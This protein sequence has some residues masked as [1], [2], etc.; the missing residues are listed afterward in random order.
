MMLRAKKYGN[1]FWLVVFKS[2]NIEGSM[3]IS[4]RYGTVDFQ[5]FEKTNRPI[6]AKGFIIT[7]V[8]PI[9]SKIYRSLLSMYQMRAK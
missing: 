5:H 6:G 9:D 1:R 2:D 7:S 3:V 4:N 8:T